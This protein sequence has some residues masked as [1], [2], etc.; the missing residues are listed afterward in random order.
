MKI[1][2][3]IHQQNVFYL[4]TSMWMMRAENIPPA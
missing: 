1:I 4:I 2:C 3:T